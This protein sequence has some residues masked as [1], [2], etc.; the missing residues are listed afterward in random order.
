[1]CSSGG[2]PTESTVTQYTSNL[3]EWAEPAWMDLLGRGVTESIMPYAPYPAQRLA[4]FSP[5]EQEAMARSGELGVSGTPDELNAA[6]Q[7]A[8]SAGMAAPGYDY[9]AGTPWNSNYIA[10]TMSFGYDPTSYMRESGYTA[11]EFDPQQNG[12]LAGYRDVG[13]Q[14]GTMT[15]ANVMSQYMD[16]YY[17]NVVDVEKREAARQADMRGANIGLEAA[18]QGSLGG[19]REAIMQ[20]ENER[21]LMQQMGDI[22]TR[23]TQAAWQ[24]GV[25]NFE[26]DRAGRGQL[27][28]FLQSQFGLNEQAKQ[29][30]AELMQQG[31]S[32]YEAARQAQEQFGQSATAMNLGALSEREQL[33]QNRYGMSEAQRL[34]Q[35]QQGLQAYNAYEAARQAQAQMGMQQQQQQLASAGMLG[36]F[37][38]QR[39]QMELERLQQM[40]MAG[41]MERDLMQQSY[42]IGYQDF[43]RQQAYPREQ[44]GLYSNLLYGAPVQPGGY[45]TTYGQGPSDL[46]QLLGGGLGGLALYGLTQNGKGG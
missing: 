22:Q 26:A 13:Y 37:A 19:Y 31:Y 4:Y 25:Q 17:Q 45:Q 30:A 10:G 2:G 39:Q 44:L 14:P 7:M 36:D 8:Y 32:V 21:N 24:S 9:Q 34:A 35:A 3:P 42:D 18:G 33:Y 46:Q 11:N 20:A 1:M 15:N 5:M 41:G 29:R 23:G 27:E 28:Q 12:Y 6:G 16:P 40:L 38:S 43:L